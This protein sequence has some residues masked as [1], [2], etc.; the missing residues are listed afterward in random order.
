MESPV[1]GTVYPLVVRF[2]RPAWLARVSI[3]CG[4]GSAAVDLRKNGVALAGL[5]GVAVSAAESLIDVE[6]GGFAPGDSLCIVP[7]NVVDCQMLQVALEFR[8][9]GA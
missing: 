2:F 9:L 1:V 3:R 4:T 8:G 6:S 7:T 5:S